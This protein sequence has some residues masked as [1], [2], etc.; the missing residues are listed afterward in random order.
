MKSLMMLP[1]ALGGFALLAAAVQAG[2]SELVLMPWPKKVTLKGERFNLT[3]SFRVSVQGEADERVYTAASR[4]LGY[5]AGRTGLFFQ[6]LYLRPEERVEHPGLILFCNRPGTLKL[7]EDESYRLEVRA[8]QI[9]LRAETGLGILRGLETLLQLLH[10]D[11]QGYY[12]PGI[13]IEDEPRFPWRGLLIDVA[14]HFMPV[15]VIKRNLD[16]MAAVKLNVLHWHLVD[17]QGFR[18]ESK[19]FPRLHLT[20][21]DGFYYTQEQIREVIQY[22]ADRGIRVVPEFDVPGHATS[23]LVAY[24]ELGS[25][26]GP[27]ELERRWGIHYPALNPAS[28]FTYAFLD[29]F[30]GEMAALFPDPY[31]HIGGDELEHPGGHEAKHWNE[32]PEIQ[33]FKQEKGLKDNAALQAYF[34]RRILK[35][36]TKYGKIMVGWDEILHPDMPRNILIQSWRGKEAMVRASK[37]GFQSILSNGYYIDLIYP[38]ADHY[39]NDPLP[40]DIPLN[41]KEKQRI[42]GGEATMWGEFVSPETID[43][44]IWPRTAAIAERLW[45][46][47]EIND[48]QDMYRRLEIIRYQLEERGLMHEKNYPMML[49]RL[50]GYRDIEPLK[51]LVDVIEPVKHYR[52]NRL[53]EHT[54]L[55]PLTRVVDAARPDATVAREFR[56]KVEQF[57]SEEKEPALFDELEQRLLQWQQN[58]ERLLPMIRLSPVLWEIESLSEDLSHVAGIGL[59]ALKAI[60]N[61]KP[62][63]SD[64]KDA[65]LQRLEQAGVPRGEAELMIL[66]AIRRLV[67]SASAE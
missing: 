12:F 19:E 20:A 47:Q 24:P 22:A 62:L 50:T 33:K 38:A 1:V 44:R 59:E 66:S 8:G 32:N 36:L 9:T 31:F 34:N 37:M 15:E 43:S 60:M 67:E 23:W 7:G 6:Q 65:S 29:R 27:Y 13:S 5:L 51:T 54:S 52:R 53:R 28:E 42:L 17:D 56:R 58:H 10:A 25:A 16:G 57:L 63:P 11:E 3:D 49:R 48:V 61:R 41:K 26:P 46:P 55:S 45:S 2:Q 18:V 14:R 4:F 21:S 39:L 30:F 40:P 35:I 64:W